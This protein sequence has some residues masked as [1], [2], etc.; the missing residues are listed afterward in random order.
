M[1]LPINTSHNLLFMSS[2]TLLINNNLLCEKI[3]FL[4][5]LNHHTKETLPITIHCNM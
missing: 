3:T 4:V 5:T 1:H 2:L